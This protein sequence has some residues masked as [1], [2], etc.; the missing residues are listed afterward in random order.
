MSYYIT[1]KHMTT[2]LKT[3]VKA[4]IDCLLTLNKTHDDPIERFSEGYNWLPPN[5]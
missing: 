2:R 3:L 5:T 4:T 1:E